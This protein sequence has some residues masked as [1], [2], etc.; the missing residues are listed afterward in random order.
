MSTPEIKT[1]EL[2]S[3]IVR[4]K[5]K[6]KEVRLRKPKGGDLRGLSLMQVSLADY[7][8]VTQL[9]PRIT[10]PVIHKHD[11]DEMG[12]DDL[13]E[14]SMEVA[15]FFVKGEMPSLATSQLDIPTK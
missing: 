12:L 8:T 11:L 2:E 10:D 9:L 14:L 1:V 15:S 7:N 4:G 6:I 5:Q 13:M 3:H